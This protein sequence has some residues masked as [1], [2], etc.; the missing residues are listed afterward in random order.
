MA[1][2]GTRPRLLLILP[3]STYQADAFIRAAR[4]LDVAL[5]VAS[6]VPSSLEHAN[7]EGLL[8]L[9][10][11]DPE[12]AARRAAMFARRH[13]FDAVLG[14]DDRTALVA[15]AVSEAL[16]LPT[17]PSESVRA[18][19]N[20]HL[21]REL[22]RQSG[23]PV[24]NFSLHTLEE[25]AREAASMARYPCVLKPLMLSASRGVIR[26]N[27]EEEFMAARRRLAHIIET[28]GTVRSY[29]CEDFIPGP[30]F[31]LEGYLVRGRLHVFAIFDKPDPLDGPYFEETIYVA[32]SRA[33]PH[34]QQALI[35]T[36][37]GAVRAL[38]LER[39]PVHVELR[40]SEGPYL[41]ELGARSI[42]G[43]CGG[44]LRFGPTGELS[45]EDVLV[46]GA[47]DLLGRPP[48]REPGARG[49]MMIPTPGSGFLDGVDGLDA[50]RSVPGVEDVLVTV[51]RGQRLVPL[52]EGSRYLGFIFAAGPNP[53]EV[54]AALRESHGKLTVHIVQESR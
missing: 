38:G 15:A 34:V 27:D 3:T 41:I 26:A 33:E 47:L 43:K 25:P 51:H 54:E 31:A 35:A 46:R 20:K 49:V 17:N 13:P 30:E 39:G 11:D 50:A 16:S 45:L 4:R 10:L 22:M 53:V 12:S 48:E 29:L 36:A 19:W 1:S 8:T 40:H 44:V 5:T 6:E 14:V 18:A 28:A 2:R 42:G 23:V 24:P 32:P 7:P 21:Q 9:D 37:V 52:P